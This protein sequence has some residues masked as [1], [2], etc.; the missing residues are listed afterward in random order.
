MRVD[1]ISAALADRGG[2]A[3]I[4]G[5]GFAAAFA[6]ELAVH[7]RADRVEVEPSGLVLLQPATLTA[8]FRATG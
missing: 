8:E 6:R 7:G 4:S 3:S 1:S 5:N 2:T